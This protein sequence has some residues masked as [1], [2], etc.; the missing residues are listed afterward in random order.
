M[1]Y[2]SKKQETAICQ[3]MRDVRALL[4]V[5]SLATDL[6][7]LETREESLEGAARLAE[8][9]VKLIRE[10]KEVYPKYEYTYSVSADG[11]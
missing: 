7:R 4:K 5:A 1:K 3:A 8:G 11:K 10:A 9:L 2:S 6:G